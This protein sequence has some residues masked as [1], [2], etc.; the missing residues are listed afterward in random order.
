MNASLDMA[1]LGYLGTNTKSSPLLAHMVAASAFDRALSQGLRNWWWGKLTRRSNAL[2]TLSHRPIKR[3]ANRSSQITSVPLDQI[4]GSESR[5][6]DFDRHFN[7]LKINNR[8][9]WIGIA[10]AHRAGVALPPI[11]LVQEGD[12]FYV[13][14]GHHRISV[15]RSLGQIQIEARIVN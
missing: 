3:A 2:Q 1:Y 11:E 12:H 7:P 4:V 9:R 8:E 15:M 5:S 14:D 13:R 6:E 10:I